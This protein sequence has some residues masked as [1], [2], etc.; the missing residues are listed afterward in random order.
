VIRYAIAIAVFL[1]MITGAYLKG[2]KDKAAELTAHYMQ[3]LTAQQDKYAHQLEQAQAKSQQL[4]AQ[5]AAKEAEITDKEFAYEARI[6]SLLDGIRTRTI[7]VRIKPNPA[8]K[9]KSSVPKDEHPQCRA[10]APRKAYLDQRVLRALTICNADRNRKIFK[11]QKLQ[12][13]IKLNLK[14]VNGIDLNGQ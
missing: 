9:A 1:S 2:A 4:A 12:S 6:D 3:Q 11:I 10:H 7:R 8:T 5:V 14:R 13:Y